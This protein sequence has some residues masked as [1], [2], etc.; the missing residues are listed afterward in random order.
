LSTKINRRDFLK[1]GALG[2]L[3]LAFGSSFHALSIG[4][5]ITPPIKG[6]QFLREKDTE[7]LLAIATS[8]LKNNY[9]GD[10]GE[11]ATERLLKALDQ[12][13]LTFSEFSQQQLMQLFDLMSVTP[14]RFL[15]GGPLTTWSKASGQQVDDFLI[16]WQTSSISLKRM[17]YSSLCKLITMTWYSQ[18]ENYHQSGYPGPPKVILTEQL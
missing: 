3:T 15:A 7:F 1:I 17:G 4:F 12:M 9:P 10:L 5:S 2:S 14:L 6:L 11:Q 13:M 16:S 8:V 18:P